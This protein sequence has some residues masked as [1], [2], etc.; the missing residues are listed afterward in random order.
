MNMA[1]IRALAQQIDLHANGGGTNFPECLSLVKAV[2]EQPAI[3]IDKI[4]IYH[5][6]DT[7]PVLTDLGEYSNEPGP[8]DRT[9]DRFPNGKSRVYR[10]EYRY[11]VAAMSG[12][13]TG[14]PKSVEEDYRRMEAY[15][16]NEWYMLGVYVVATVSYADAQGCHRLEHLQSAGVWGVESDCGEDIVEIEN[17]QLDELYSHLDVFGVD[18]SNWD[19]RVS[20]AEHKEK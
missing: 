8:E 6:T 5:E 13:E 11:F 14:N 9:I 18:L 3:R 16:H 17:E 2:L 20:V 1:M 12:D 7:C 15:N 10:N 19:D 4:V